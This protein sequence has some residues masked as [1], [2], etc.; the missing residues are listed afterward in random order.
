MI[1]LMHCIRQLFSVLS[2]SIRNLMTGKQQSSLETCTVVI[3]S[4][5]KANPY[6]RIYY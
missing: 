1:T 5:I 3:E 4:D 2:T 6:S